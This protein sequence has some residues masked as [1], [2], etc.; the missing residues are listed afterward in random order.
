MTHQG[1]VGSKPIDPFLAG[2]RCLCPACG[3][4]PL[5]VGL[6]KIPDQCANCGADFRSADTGDGPAVFVMLI[7]G[8]IIVPLT[9]ITQIVFHPPMWVH[10]LIWLPVTAALCVGVM[11]PFKAILFALQWKHK[12]A[13]ARLEP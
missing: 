13:E 6:I 9:L 2:L 10:M 5:F 11:R 3:R 8:F 12:A 4:A 1:S 7:V